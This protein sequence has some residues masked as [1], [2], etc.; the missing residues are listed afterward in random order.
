MLFFLPVPSSLSFF[1]APVVDFFVPSLDDDEAE[2]DFVDVAVPVFLTPVLFAVVVDDLVPV[3]VFVVPDVVFF[4][5]L[6][7]VFDALPGALAEADFVALAPVAGFVFAVP[8]A[9]FVPAGFVTVVLTVE[10]M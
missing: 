6:V 5:P 7:A 3:A 10:V 8:E 1:V 4:T 9:A 2:A